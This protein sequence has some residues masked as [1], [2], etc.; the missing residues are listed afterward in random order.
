MGPE[1]NLERRVIERTAHLEVAL[2]EI[3]SFS[4]GRGF[5]PPLS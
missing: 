3:D 1:V 5:R 4:G 2:K